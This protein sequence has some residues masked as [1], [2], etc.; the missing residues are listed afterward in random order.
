MR[1]RET[2]AVNG[3]RKPKPGYTPL[4]PSTGP[5]A[6]KLVIAG[7]TCAL[8][9]N[10]A[11]PRTTSGGMAAITSGTTI[12]DGIMTIAGQISA[13]RS[14]SSA[15]DVHSKGSM[16]TLELITNQS[17]HFFAIV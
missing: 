5:I 8:K 2:N 6:R 12:Q 10:I 4:W 3:L 7:T 11:G 14:S 17:P 16:R 15:L 9:E 1:M 13:L